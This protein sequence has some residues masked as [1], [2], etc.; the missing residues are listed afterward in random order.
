MSMR[1]LLLLPPLGSVLPPDEVE[2]GMSGSCLF[3]M[4]LPALAEVVACEEGPR[5]ITEGENKDGAMGVGTALGLFLGDGSGGGI[6]GRCDGGDVRG[7]Q[8]WE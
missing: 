6:S 4:L 2:P 3:C 1:E 5:G 8:G 7:E